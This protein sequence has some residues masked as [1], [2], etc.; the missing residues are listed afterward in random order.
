MIKRLDLG[1]D[2][3][4]GGPNGG[5]EEECELFTKDPAKYGHWGAQV[6]SASRYGADTEEWELS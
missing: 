1:S 2:K 3:G 4:E 6:E 5:Q